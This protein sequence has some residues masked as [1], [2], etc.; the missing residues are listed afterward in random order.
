M[1]YIQLL[2][3]FTVNDSLLLSK[4]SVPS[5]ADSVP[6]TS[7]RILPHQLFLLFPESTIFLWYWLILISIQSSCYF[8]ISIIIIIIVI[9]SPDSAVSFIYFSIFLFFFPEKLL[10]RIIHT[11][12]LQ[13]F[14]SSSFLITLQ[15]GHQLPRLS[16]TYTLFNPL[17]N[18]KRYTSN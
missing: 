17:V 8:P 6:P 5:C 3:C 15:S 13:F 7:S 4:A 16:M 1:T 11:C 10:K 18:F 14:S 2:L 9:T 12:F